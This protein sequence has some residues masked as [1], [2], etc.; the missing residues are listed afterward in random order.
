M[1]PS[2]TTIHGWHGLIGGKW[3]GRAVVEAGKC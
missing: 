3:T 1:M 2:L